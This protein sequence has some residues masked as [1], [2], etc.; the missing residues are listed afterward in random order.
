MEQYV[1]SLKNLS[2]MITPNKNNWDI[3][4]I[5]NSTKEM[6]LSVD[7]VKLKDVDWI[8]DIIKMGDKTLSEF[9]LVESN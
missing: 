1:I 4:V 3:L 8:M 6:W 2:V 7:E 5:L 9:N